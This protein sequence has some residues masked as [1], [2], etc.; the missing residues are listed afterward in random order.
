MSFLPQ[1]DQDWGKE[2]HNNNNKGRAVTEYVREKLG[3]PDDPTR[4]IFVNGIALMIS[5]SVAILLITCGASLLAVGGAAAILGG[6][7]L[8]IGAYVLEKLD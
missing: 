1:E 6:V 7:V 2:R 3:T 8:G 5:A 4:T